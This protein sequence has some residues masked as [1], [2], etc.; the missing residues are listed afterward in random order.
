MVVAA[1]WC[2]FLPRFLSVVSFSVLAVRFGLVC[3]WGLLKWVGSTADVVDLKLGEFSPRVGP[4]GVWVGFD[5][6]SAES[7]RL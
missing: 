3:F 1:L 2:S 5:G 7:I 4:H 6:C